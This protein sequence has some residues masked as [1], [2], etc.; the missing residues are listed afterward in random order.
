MKTTPKDPRTFNFFLTFLEW[1]AQQNKFKKD[2]SEMNKEELNSCLKEF[3]VSCRKQ[4]GSYYKK[5]SIKDIRAAIN[6]HL[7]K[8]I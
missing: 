8:K 7:K 1:I 3:Y 4:D 5:T 2:I 6:R